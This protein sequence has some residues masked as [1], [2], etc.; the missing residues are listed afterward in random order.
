[1]LGIKRIYERIELNMN[2]KILNNKEELIQLINELGHAILPGLNVQE[3]W[4]TLI[5]EQK[6]S[7]ETRTYPCPKS[8]INIPI[9]LIATNRS[10]GQKAMVSCVVKI[11]NTFEYSNLQNFRADRIRHCIEQGSLFDMQENK[12]KWA[13]KM[14]V[15][16]RFN[17]QS[18]LVPR[19]GI[20]WAKNVL[21]A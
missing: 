18:I 13:W 15:L 12:V 11:T 1:M 3:P 16:A 20:V 4:C 21:E 9:A 2:L 17:L 6:K 10:E 7:I 8:K 19:K 14:A 5:A